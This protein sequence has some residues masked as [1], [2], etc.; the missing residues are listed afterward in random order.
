MINAFHTY[1]EWTRMSTKKNRTTMFSQRL[2]PDVVLKYH[3]FGEAN[4]FDELS[5]KNW[6]T[7][8]QKQKEKRLKSAPKTRHLRWICKRSV[9]GA[10]QVGPALELT[11]TR[12]CTPSNG[13]INIAPIENKQMEA[14]KKLKEKP[15]LKS[16]IYSDETARAIINSQKIPGNLAKNVAKYRRV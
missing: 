6:N 4:I 3:N 5:C 1:Y 12:D 8:K 2:R 9:R 16:F 15:S 11:S 13:K 14:K 7:S 10:S